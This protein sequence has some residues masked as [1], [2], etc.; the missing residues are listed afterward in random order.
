ML[1]FVFAKRA[2]AASALVSRNLAFSRRALSSGYP[3]KDRYPSVEEYNKGR[4]PRLGERSPRAAVV[5][6]DGSTLMHPII[7][8]SKTGDPRF[9]DEIGSS[10]ELHLKNDFRNDPEYAFPS[11]KDAMPDANKELL[12]RYKKKIKEARKKGKESAAQ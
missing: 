8:L 7:D 4:W 11:S 3:K 1:S 2:C 6:T 12:K 5:L 10:R 9:P